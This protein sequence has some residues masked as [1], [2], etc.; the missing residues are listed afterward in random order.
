MRCDVRLDL[1]AQ[2]RPREGTSSAATKGSRSRSGRRRPGTSAGKSRCTA[3]ERT[4][5]MSATYGGLAVRGANL[6]YHRDQ[7]HVSATS[8]A[9][10]Q[11]ASD[12]SE[13]EDENLDGVSV[14]SRESEGSRELVVNLVDVL[15]QSAVVH[16]PVDRVVPRILHHEEQRK[17]GDDLGQAGERH[18]PRLHPDRSRERVKQVNLMGAR[19]DQSATGDRG[20]RRL[21]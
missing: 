19:S 12:G 7:V 18:L 8:P 10:Q 20:V 3:I 21:E 11:R 1:R 17:L 9:P 4:R 16:Q 15:V 13:S 14:L 6:A 5:V 2:R